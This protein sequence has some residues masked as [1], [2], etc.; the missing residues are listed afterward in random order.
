MDVINEIGDDVSSRIIEAHWKAV[1]R[2][3]VLRNI[4][5]RQVTRVNCDG[6][7]Y[8]VKTYRIALLRRIFGMRPNSFSCQKQIE[9]LS[10][11]CLFNKVVGNWQI[12]ILEDVGRFS[13]YELDLQSPDEPGTLAY[14]AA[15]GNLLA[16]LHKRN[17]HHGDTKTPNFVV[18]ENCPN[19]PKVAIVDCDRI[20]QYE[21]IPAA[22]M[23]CNLAQFIESALPSRP[24][25]S[26][27]AHFKAFCNAYK[28]KMGLDDAAWKHLFLL[29]LD[30]AENKKNIE[31][32][33]SQ[34]ALANLKSE[35]GVE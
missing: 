28:E 22:K 17:I 34:E 12:T 29:A 23:A 25:D 16:E 6:V 32:I 26:V 11:R 27:V 7:S 30:I 2:G 8:I 1:E 19:L 9:G 3:D 10:P 4:G 18:N 35:V 15:A 14:F 33:T 13:L 31:R 20:C 21:E 24:V 5:K